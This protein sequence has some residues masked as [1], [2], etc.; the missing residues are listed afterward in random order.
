MY[1]Y[2]TLFST[3]FI[4][5]SLLP[6]SPDAVLAVMVSREAN[7]PLCILVATIGSYLGACLNYALGRG[8]HQLKFL[9]RFSPKNKELEKSWQR[10]LKYGQVTLFFSWVPFIGDS[11]TFLAGYLKLNLTVFSIWVLAGRL[12]RFVLVAYS[13]SLLSKL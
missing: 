5:A 11:F 12:F 7:I 2:L 8:V 3:A 4:A 9:E 10:Y 1:W 6:G 13:S